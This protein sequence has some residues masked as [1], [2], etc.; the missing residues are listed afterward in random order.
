MIRRWWPLCLAVAAGAVGWAA[1][2]DSGPLDATRFGADPAPG[3][4]DTRALQAAFDAAAAQKQD[5]YLPAGHYRISRPLVFRADSRTLHGDGPSRTILAGDTSRHDLL[6]L[7]QTQNVTVR[8]LRLEGSH[9]NT[10]D[11]ANTGKAVECYNTRRTRLLRLYSYGTG[12]IAFDN[13]GTDTT[14]EDS[15][16][17]DYGR[18]G[19]LINDGGT[20]RRCRFQN[21]DGWRMTSEMQGIYAAAGR[22]NIL[23]EDC[24]FINAGIYAIQL[25]GS[26][27]GVYTENITI[28]R[29]TF[30]RCPRVLVCAAGGSG[31]IYRNIRFLGNTIRGTQEKSLHIGKFN[32]STTNGTELLIEGNV[33][34]DAGPG[35]GIYLTPWGDAPLQGI[36]IRNNEFRAPNRS[37]YNGFVH[38][39]GAKDVVIEGNSFSG[40]GHDGAQEIVSCGLDLRQGE[41][42]RV[43]RNRFRF[44]EGAGAARRV[45]G[46]R[47]TPAARD[48]VIEAND[49][50][51]TGR[52]HCYAIRAEAAVAPGTVRKNQV[53]RARL[54]LAT[55][56]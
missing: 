35:F 21:R 22:D 27:N 48:T 28:Q 39:A 15:V 52:E 19:Y 2:G 18:I 16:C 46:I 7:E 41:K 43:L 31:P 12:Y 38:V 3:G 53:T 11:T 33:F 6:R 24:E 23:I 36:R 49:F 37:S 5:V 26:Q 42:L 8:D 20:V 30:V 9:V 50:Q 29:N 32:G 45:E 17:E 40:I 1:P 44:W 51:G 55:N 47:L 13:G 25:W 54:D 10:S 34:E 4:D 14:L 56:R